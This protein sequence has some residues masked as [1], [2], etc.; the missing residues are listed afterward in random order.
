MPWP[1]TVAG[2][3][4]PPPHIKNKPSIPDVAHVVIR[5]HIV[6]ERMPECHRQWQR[7][8]ADD[9]SIVPTFYCVVC[10]IVG[11]FVFVQFLHI[12]M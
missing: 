1:M 4:S 2:N 9:T 5:K 3:Y 11:F 8:V 10:V 7:P 6:L 12:K